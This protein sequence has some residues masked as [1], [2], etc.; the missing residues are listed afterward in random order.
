MAFALHLS[1][2]RSASFS[3]WK[4]NITAFTLELARRLQIIRIQPIRAGI[5]QLLP[6]CVP[7]PDRPPRRVPKPRRNSQRVRLC[8]QAHNRRLLRFRNV[9]YSAP[10]H[11]GLVVRASDGRKCRTPGGIGGVVKAGEGS[12]EEEV[13]R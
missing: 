11:G 3:T 7:R 6:H 12:V 4:L 1:L 2:Q 5:Q 10:T 13:A 8:Y 9:T